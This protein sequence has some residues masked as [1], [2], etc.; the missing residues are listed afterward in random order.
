M[1]KNTKSRAPK[2]TLLPCPFCGY[3]AK[4][5]A[6]LEADGEIDKKQFVIGCSNKTGGCPGSGPTT[7]GD[8]KALAAQSWNTRA[9]ETVWETPVP[10]NDCPPGLFIF[11]GILAIKTIYGNESFC[12]DGG[13]TFW[14]GTNA[15]EDRNKLIVRPVRLPDVSRL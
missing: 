15:Q 9:P 2:L 1:K 4:F 8:T 12:V 5:S 10:L 7:F 13:E 14:G 11:E 6:P 3:K